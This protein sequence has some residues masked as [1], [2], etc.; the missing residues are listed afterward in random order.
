MPLPLQG[1]VYIALGVLAS[2][3]HTAHVE[4][5]PGPAARGPRGR[6]CP[7]REGARGPALSATSDGRWDS[8]PARPA[9]AIGADETRARLVLVPSARRTSL[10]AML[11]L[12][13]VN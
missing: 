7:S 12:G 13:L 6:H 4:G 2:C 11:W 8:R 9:G 10:A 3:M 5:L 1:G